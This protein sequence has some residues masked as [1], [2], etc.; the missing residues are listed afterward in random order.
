MK[1]VCL[2]LGVYPKS[3]SEHVSQLSLL[4]AYILN[5]IVI[6]ID[7]LQPPCSNL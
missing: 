2:A 6:L 5:I 7:E 3:F 1:Y 4:L